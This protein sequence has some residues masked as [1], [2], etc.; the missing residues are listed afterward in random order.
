[1]SAAAERLKTSTAVE[2]LRK[3]VDAPDRFDLPL[4]EVEPTQLQAADELLQD[5]IGKIRLLQ[6]RAETGGVKAIR[7]PA[8]IVPLLFAHTTYKSYPESWLTEQKWDRLVKWLDTVST[9]RV[10]GI[11]TANVS[12]IDDWIRRLEAAGHFVSC[13]SGTTGKCAMM[14]ASAADMEWNRRDSVAAFS[15]G[16]GVEP[17]RD[18]KMFG[19]APVAHVPRNLSIRHALID[20]F[21]IPGSTSFAYPV[22]PI[23]IGKI[24]GM[25][26][27]RKRIADGTAKPAEIAAH[28]ATA[29]ER[30]EAMDKAVGIAAEALVK[31]RHEK[32]F[33]S[34]M[35]AALYQVAEAVRAMGYSGKD[36]HPENSLYVGGGLKGAVLPPNYREYVLET[37]N[38]PREDVFY[39]YGMQELASAMPRCRSGRYHVP[40][41]VI[42]LVLDQ[43]GD[44]LLPR[45]S[46][47]IEG[48]AAFFDVALDGRW[49]GVISGDKVAVDY[50]E[51]ACGRSSPSIRDNINRYADGPGGDKISCAGT[52]DAYV[53]GAS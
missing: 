21:A 11:D 19:L 13:S 1:M 26:A 49:N 37:F 5:R 29:K 36:F 51:C 50:G 34:G 4:A 7:E 33:L 3:L 45:T 32:L 12:D 40:P 8:D 27:L 43:G 15:W 2:R 10:V 28:E 47:E 20:A 17:A 35:W 44:N 38:L 23:T 52:I 39:M 18:R 42:C 25:V 24:T 14:N 22:P 9:H 30:Q 48:R 46:G 16:S 31:S 41:W 6:N 53:R